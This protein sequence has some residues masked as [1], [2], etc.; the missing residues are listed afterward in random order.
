MND[1]VDRISMEHISDPVTFGITMSAVANAVIKADKSGE[2]IFFISIP[3]ING[4]PDNN[5][6][7]KLQGIAHEK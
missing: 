5:L 3:N 6:A 2:T 4:K 7:A 1:E